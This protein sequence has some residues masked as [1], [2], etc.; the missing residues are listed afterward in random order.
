MQTC[1]SCNKDCM[2]SAKMT[3]HGPP[4]QS[5]PSLLAAGPAATTA[6]AS[7]AASCVPQSCLAIGRSLDT[8]AHTAGQCPSL[9]CVTNSY[10]QTAA[11]NVE[12]NVVTKELEDACAV[13]D[14]HDSCVLFLLHVTAAARAINLLLLCAG[15][16]RLLR[17]AEINRVN[18]LCDQ[19]EVIKAQARPS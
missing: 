4:A 15:D 11:C 3:L 19:M 1:S 10:I 14:G 2:T 16:A 5:A 12:V 17:K 13:P 18:G 8:E 6:A 7:A 9:R